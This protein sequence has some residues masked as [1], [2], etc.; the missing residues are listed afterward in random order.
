MTWW[1][2]GSSVSGGLGAL[3]GGLA[4]YFIKFWLDG[5]N[6]K[7]KFDLKKKEILFNKEIEACSAF[8]ALHDEIQQLGSIENTDFKLID[9]KLRD[10]QRRHSAALS[11]DNRSRIKFCRSVAIWYGDP[12]EVTDEV[13]K[14]VTAEALKNELFVVS[15]E[16]HFVL[17]DIVTDF[18]NQIRGE[19]A[20]TNEKRGYHIGTDFP[21]WVWIRDDNES[22]W[23]KSW[24][25][26]PQLAVRDP[27]RAHRLR[28][29]ALQHRIKAGRPDDADKPQDGVGHRAHPWA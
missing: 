18:L 5:K 20:P 7:L 14:W 15:M 27:Q 19:E 16:Y 25:D 8:I 17:D 3:L 9:Q 2:L 6:E 24:V 22:P 4:G 26:D 12:Y 21:D 29:L 10:F 11:K 13:L 1:L 28:L 23:G